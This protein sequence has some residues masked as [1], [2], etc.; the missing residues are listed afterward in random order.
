MRHRYSSLLLALLLAAPLWAAEPAP[1]R[2]TTSIDFGWYFHL[3]DVVD[4][5]TPAVD[6][7]GWRLLD[8]PHDWSIEGQYAK[9]NPGGGSVAFLPTGIGWYQK[10]LP[11]NPDWQGRRVAVVFDGVFMNSTVWLNGHEL[12][13][14]P[15]GYLGF[16]YDL[17]PY[18][19]QGTNVLSVRVD[20][21][22]QPAARFYT[23]SG[24]YRHV[25]LVTTSSVHIPMD[26]TF[27]S[28]PVVTDGEAS[29]HVQA[30]VENL[31][32]GRTGV[33]MT[34]IV[35]DPQGREV[36]RSTQ[37]EAMLNDNC[38]NRELTTLADSL[39][40]HSPQLWSIE[41]PQ[42]YTLRTELRRG[43]TLVDSY[44]TPFGIR[45]IEFSVTEGFKLNGTPLKFKG[46][47]LHQQTAPVGSAMPEDLWHKRL[48]QLKAMGCNAI[49]TSHYA[50]PPFV[51]NMC[52]SLGLMVM[53]ELFD[54]WYQ[55][56]GA[57]KAKYDYGYY[58][59]D[60]WQRDLADFIRR[61]RNH[62]SV[63][64]WSMGNEVWGYANHLYLQYSINRMFRRM[65]GTRPTTQAW[66]LTEYLDIA[67]FNANG[68]GRGDI[69]RF[70][71]EQPQK[72][73][74][75]TEIPHTRSTRGV[76]RTIGAYNAWVNPERFG[77]EAKLFPLDSYTEREI[78]NFDKRYASSYDNQTRKIS[79][80]EQ[81]KQTRKYPFFLG[82]FR[83]TAFDYLGESWGWPA[84][85]NN[86]GII[87]MCGFPKD[88]Y[89]LY[90]SLWTTKPMVHI[91]PHWTW[92]GMEGTEIP[93]VAYTNADAVELLLN[94]RSLGRKPMDPE[95]LEI[96]WKVPYKAG[97]L[98]AVAYKDGVAVARDSQTTA[99][100]P[101]AIRLTPDRPSMQANHRDVLCVTVDV[102]DS[103][104][105]LVPSADNDIA[106]TVSGPC[107]LLGTE[108]GDILDVRPAHTLQ[109]KVFMGKALLML[110]ATGQSGTLKIT[111]TAG[112]LKRGAC[113]V[114]VH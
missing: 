92:P 21:S 13:Y 59:L 44:A 48:L 80:R 105:T 62:P 81:W 17:T 6:Y 43:G 67:G 72:M 73:A 65:D 107:K 35:V 108:N 112:N 70:H 97:T 2:T 53:D 11:W 37:P 93:V 61:D 36:A 95:Q 106:F 18:L 5:Q 103:R 9:D 83:W 24:I 19:T 23:G 49:R 33:T 55:W 111:A 64:I 79:V 4:G 42:L 109:R 74:I 39:I 30:Q 20:N 45:R 96:V 85:T 94:G 66:A 3:G 71:R 78:F 88:N 58:F 90:Q 99:T 38:Y 69:D 54:G 46:V 63:M 22:R 101:A 60:W 104:G 50:Y 14:R 56:K 28:T 110:Q 98:S 52:D 86:Y 87:D 76:Y 82:E 15:N 100:R 25:K 113:Q 31:T 102:V 7:H 26:G 40:V 57:N 12:G 34:S 8:V 75:G 68:E 16:S 10:E 47:C 32:G 114:K 41:R 77:K 89:Y 91:L 29:V 1:P 84:R 27:V 51:L